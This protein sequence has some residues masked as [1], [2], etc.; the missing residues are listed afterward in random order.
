[1]KISKF[2]HGFFCWKKKKWIAVIKNLIKRKIKPKKNWLTPPQIFPFFLDQFQ[3]YKIRWKKENNFPIF[4]P[5]FWKMRGKIETKKQNNLLLY[6][7]S[8]Y[9]RKSAMQ[10]LWTTKNDWKK[11]FILPECNRK[12]EKK[13]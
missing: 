7:Y 4:P 9:E 8:Y 6:Y 11:E 5:I 3:I 10:M 13:L 2:D 1:M 12:Y